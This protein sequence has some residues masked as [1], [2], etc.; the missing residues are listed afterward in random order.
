MWP[1]RPFACACRACGRGWSTRTRAIG[2]T[3]VRWFRTCRATTPSNPISR[4]AHDDRE[5]LT[6]GGPHTRRIRPGHEGRTLA[7]PS[8]RVGGTARA[9]PAAGDR[10]LL[11]GT[12]LPSCGRAGERSRGA[13]VPVRHLPHHAE[14]LGDRLPVAGDV[15]AAVARDSLRV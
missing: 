10:P 9:P 11:R 7:S 12:R 6:G 8:V 15:R 14:F 3:T 4:G 13:G 1:A 5:S 2:G